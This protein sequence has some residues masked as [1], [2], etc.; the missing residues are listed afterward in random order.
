[1]N[2]YST[3]HS[4]LRKNSTKKNKCEFCGKEDGKIDNALLKGKKHSKNLDNY[5]KLCRKCH[6][7]YDHPY[8]YKHTK[9]S[10]IKIGKHSSERIKKKGVSD[11]FKYSRK[12]CNITKEHKNKISQSVRGEKHPK[13]KL[14]EEDVKYIFF[15]K[16]K[17]IDLANQYNI[18]YRTIRNIKTKKT[19][20]HLNL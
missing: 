19:W 7:H 3:I 20:K 12:G 10:K 4:W 14:K 16:E 6:Y 1:M 2:N 17:D 5:I 15:S 8:G 9:E 13:S 11:N 18:T